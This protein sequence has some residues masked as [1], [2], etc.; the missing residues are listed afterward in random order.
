MFFL[1]KMAMLWSKNS[2]ILAHYGNPDRSGDQTARFKEAKPFT[3][4]APH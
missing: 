2:N 1:A 4:L 3:F